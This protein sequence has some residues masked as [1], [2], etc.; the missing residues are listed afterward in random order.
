MVRLPPAGTGAISRSGG[1]GRRRFGFEHLDAF[2]EASELLRSSHDGGFR[3]GR[4]AAV[5]RLVAQEAF[6]L[7]TGGLGENLPLLGVVKV[8]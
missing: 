7:V 8:A 6:K 1:I 4:I 2:D 5:D 3:T